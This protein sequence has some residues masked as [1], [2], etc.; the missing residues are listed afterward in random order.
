MKTIRPECTQGIIN[1]VTGSDF[2]YQ[3]WPTVAQDENGTLYAV[4]SG[5][6]V[7]HV[8]PFGKTVMYISRNGGKTW[9]P[10]MVIN[11]S[12]LDDRDAGIVYLGG[13]KLLI[14]W[15]TRAATAYTSEKHQALME[16]ATPSGKCLMQGGMDAYQYMTPEQTVIGSYVR[17]SE[18]YGVTWG[19][20]VRLP[21]TAP[22]GPT[23]CKDGSLI[24]LGTEHG[25]PAGSVGKAQ[26]QLHRSR[27]NGKTWE[28]ESVVPE[29]SWLVGNEIMCEPHVMELPDGRLLGGV[30]IERRVPYTIATTVSE[31]GGKTW[32]EPVC[33][34]VSGAPPHFLLHSSGALVCTFGRREEPYGN[35]AMVSY[36]L[37]KTWEAEYILAESESRDLGYGST[38]ELPDGSLMSVYYQRH[39]EDNYT[40]LFYTKWQLE[41]N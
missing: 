21:V 17:L 11:D 31:D 18:D 12:Y 35:H 6:R 28:K 5:F 3:A 2:A 16:L 36:D 7:R 13:G 22:H 41:K 40:S 32:S 9:T 19:E 8:C 10:P 24:Y 37:G 29:P 20:P 15:F 25:R 38:L 23:L 14:S 30:R 27:D 4:A 34:D 39:P 1:R 33:T 26:I